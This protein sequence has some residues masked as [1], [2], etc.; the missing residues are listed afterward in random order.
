MK[1][2]NV[3]LLL[4]CMLV[5]S[6]TRSYATG[7]SVNAAQTVA[8]NFFKFQ[9][10]AAASSSLT[11]NLF[12]AQADSA[13]TVDFYIFNASPA[14]GFVIVSGD[15]RA[16][17][18][19]AYSSE[20]N[21][22]PNYTKAP[23]IDWMKSAG[24]REHYIV[25]NNIPAT[26]TTQ[27]LWADYIQGVN[28]QTQRAG[29]GTYLL[30]TTWDQSPYYNS[31]CPPAATASTSS[32][33]SVTG[34]VATAMA[35]IMKFWN[36]PYK[37]TGSHTYNDAT[38][39]GYSMNYGNL[40]ATFSGVHNWA[41]MPNTVTSNTSPVDSLMYELGVAV[42]MDYSPSGSGA[43]V[44]TAESGGSPCSQTVYPGNYYYNPNTIKGVFL[45][46]YTDANWITLMET[47]INQGRVVQYEGDDATQ[48]GHT[49]VMDGYQTQTG[50]DYLHMNWGWSGYY[51]GFFSV[52][53]LTTGSGSSAFNPVQNDGALI[54]IEPLDSFKVTVSAGR[55]TICAG[56][57]TKLTVKG[58]PTNATYTWTP[59]TGLS[60]ST[61]A[62]TVVTATG[63]GSITY[64][65]T[66]DSAGFIKEHS[67]VTLTIS[68]QPTA[69]TSV[70]LP[71]AP[72]T[73][74]TAVYTVPAVS[75]ATSYTWTVSGTGWSGT[76]STNSITLTAG[77][78]TASVSVTANNA[79][80]AS[81]PYVFSAPHAVGP[82]APTSVTLP[83]APCTN[84]T[85]VYTVP[86]VSGATSYTWTVSG[87][88]WS[89][90]SSTNSITLTAGTT[91]ASVS[92]S[93]N[94]AC[95]ASTPYVFTA[96]R[97]AGP[98][99]P[100]SVTLP[101]TPCPSSTAVYTV[102]TV[103]G[104][105]S[106]TWTVSGTGWSGT[107][108]TTS[109]T[110]TAGTITGNVSVTANNA[111]GASTP[112]TFTAPVSPLPAA[113]TSVTLPAAPCTNAT[114]TYTVPA[115]SGATSYTWTVSGTG[116]SGTSSTNSI[117][118][119][120]GTSTATV[121]VKANNACGSGAVYTFSAP[122]ASGP[123]APTSVTLPTTPCQNATA[124]YTVPAVSGAVS[125]TWTVSGTGWSGTSSTNSI[126][127][128]AGG[129]TGSV[130]VTA[131]NACGSSAPY[132]FTPASSPLPAAATNISIPSPICSGTSVTFSTP[133]IT[134]AATYD[135]TLNGTGWTGSSTSN[136]IT[137]TAGTG[138]LNISVN[139]VNTCG[140]GAPYS[141][142]S[143]AVLATPV[144]S[145]TLSSQS[146]MTSNDV[147]VTF[148]G[149]APAGT[150]YTWDFD[151]GTASPGTGAG[152]QTVSWTTTGTK[153]ITLSLDNGGCTSS[154]VSDTVQVS[155]NNTGINTLSMPLNS[156]SIAPNPVSSTLNITLT[157][158]ASTTVNVEIFDMA[159]RLIN[160][161]YTG[162]LAAGKKGITFNAEN[163]AS[164]VYVVKA[165][166]GISSVQ[167]RFIK[168]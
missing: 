152:P 35:Q 60:C 44:T 123:A 18:V 113:P 31:L 69:P 32:S 136:S 103:S 84:S 39:Q 33:K 30:T 157:S 5:V 104:A 19:I 15:D 163:I 63:T 57:T 79:C 3:L 155:V 61:C 77:T 162:E 7:V 78:A 114:A 16:I 141:S 6:F 38:S 2:Q 153:V 121:T 11:M 17:P 10:P 83:T 8:L 87:T 71:T 82:T 118:L 34:C 40:S 43:Y 107:S 132:V 116:W 25:A 167:K 72:C 92:V 76:S 22:V 37:G 165:T 50:G 134:D 90:T 149:T 80:G 130:S 59:T 100:T 51:D 120:A 21:F 140:A 102:P 20:T 64:T 4:L 133:S 14:K 26:A 122:H 127:L 148:T 74:S 28:P 111:C 124:V 99:A 75:G 142:S 115:V 145:Y 70:T 96:T 158:S 128:T 24:K 150:T 23:V 143:V 85:A 29:S 13:N 42:E 144:A 108:A 73:N 129:S 131:N 109:A 46:S 119:T 81:T 45:S 94:N 160:V 67:S 93:A 27:A 55:T 164:G 166:D 98:T 9:Y 106:Y 41:A 112:Y 65:C 68:P 151:G 12:Y 49:W 53:N 101:S 97:A 1:K 147:T 161:V 91:N 86:A 88:G 156:I 48:G 36:Y 47:E 56:D 159:G 126:T 52:T 110:L 66:A 135:W 146:V 168:L 125:Y 58:A 139:G 62:T 89:G 154:T 137:L 138:P 54:G 117:T 95:G 105:T